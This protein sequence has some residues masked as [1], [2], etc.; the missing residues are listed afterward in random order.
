VPAGGGS[1]EILTRVDTTSEGQIHW[2]IEVLPGGRAIV[3]TAGASSVIDPRI[4]V[5]DMGTGDIKDL[6]PGSFPRYS[7][8]GHL[9]FMEADGAT[10]LVAP[11]DLETLELTGAP[12]PVVDGLL[13]PDGWPLFSLSQ[14]GELR[15]ARPARGA[16]LTPVWVNRD[17]TAQEID[18]GWG[19][20]GDP[21]YSGLALSPGGDRLAIS[22]P[23]DER[24]VML[25]LEES[26]EMELILVQ[27]LF[28]ELKE[29]MG[30]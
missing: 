14:T 28:E 13:H 24:F 23:D 10:L 22:I 15:Y 21:T 12:L 29:R 11:F 20:R 18:P 8:T 6:W 16:D 17:G 27:N 4:A 26:R 9:L 5:L 30:N 1:P 25:R 2:A 19:H 3:Y 7:E